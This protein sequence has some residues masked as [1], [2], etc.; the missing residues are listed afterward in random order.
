MYYIKS[1]DKKTSIIVYIIMMTF[2][3]MVMFPVIALVTAISIMVIIDEELHY[4]EEL[5]IASAPRFRRNCHK[6]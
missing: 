2:L 3:I 1:N 5:K 6:T 4:G